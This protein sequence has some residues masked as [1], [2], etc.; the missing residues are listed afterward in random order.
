MHGLEATE[1]KK[2]SSE[3]VGAFAFLSPPTDDNEVSFALYSHEDEMKT[4]PSIMT[5]KMKI[6]GQD[7]TD[8][9]KKGRG[10]ARHIF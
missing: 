5:V 3:E 9:V 1:D 4:A 7:P 6:E 8:G 10:G 2:T